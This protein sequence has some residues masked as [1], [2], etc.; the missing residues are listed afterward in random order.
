MFL[1]ILVLCASALAEEG[2]KEGWDLRTTQCYKAFLTHVDW[3][4]AYNNCVLEGAELV[5]LRSE[6]EKQ[7]S[8][9]KTKSPPWV[10]LYSEERKWSWTDGREVEDEVWGPNQPSDRQASSCGVYYPLNNGFVWDANCKTLLPYICRAPSF[11]PT[12]APPTTPPH[13]S[14][15]CQVEGSMTVLENVILSAHNAKRA[16][17]VQTDPLCYSS[18]LQ[19]QAWQ[20]ALTL[21][22]KGGL[23]HSA[24]KYG[25][26][27]FSALY[28]T[29]IPLPRYYEIAVN[30][31]Y[32]EVKHYDWSHPHSGSAYGHFTQLVW[33]DSFNVGC[34]H[35]F[36]LNHSG[37]HR[38]IVVCYYNPSGNE[39]GYYKDNVHQL[40]EHDLNL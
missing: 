6:E 9:E 2:C 18:Y 32:R 23:E 11:S 21:G 29:S 31:W 10:G 30:N 20:Y 36:G 40:I 5:T 4:T 33:A 28:H 19:S 39:H 8:L 7:Y 26:N 14:D 27:L 34:S 13:R 22:E 12:L 3:H 1:L 38:I 35:A 17:H 15:G 24:S 25:E 16:L 37:K